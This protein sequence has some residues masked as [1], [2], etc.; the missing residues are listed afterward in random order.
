VPTPQG[1]IT[2]TIPPNTSSGKKLRI[3]G[4]GIKSDPPGDLFAEIQIVL[5]E[6]LSDEDRQQLASISGRYQQNPRVDLRW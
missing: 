3:K 6:N 5:P 2:L 1:T 4:H